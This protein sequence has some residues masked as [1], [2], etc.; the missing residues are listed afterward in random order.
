MFLCQS[1]IIRVNMKILLSRA[2]QTIHLKHM[3]F[4]SHRWISGMSKA[5]TVFPVFACST[6]LYQVVFAIIDKLLSNETYGQLLRK[7]KLGNIFHFID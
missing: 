3:G 1:I 2:E 5:M 4:G 7:K 6:G